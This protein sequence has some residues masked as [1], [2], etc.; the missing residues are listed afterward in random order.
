MTENKKCIW[1]I[2]KYASPL[3]YGFGSRHF[4][5]A[6]EFNRLGHRAVVISS[7]SNHL[8]NIPNFKNLYTKEVIDNVETLWIK[9]F[10]Y[11]G[12]NSFRR[13]LS[14]ID[15]ELKLLLMPVK[16]LSNPDVIICSSLSLFTIL[17]GYIFRK[18]FKCKLI[19]EI[20]DIW[21]LTIIEEGGF[22]KRNPFVI[23]LAWIEQFGY[24][25]ADLIVG[26]MPN[27]AEHVKNVCEKEL[28]CFCIPFGYDPDLYQEQDPLPDGYEDTYIPKNKFIIGYAGSIGVTNA[29]EPLLQCAIEMR[30]KSHIHFLIL[31][32]GDLLSEYKV[33]TSDLKNITFVPKVKKTQVQMFLRY[34]DVLYFSVH[35][36]KVWR[37]GLSLNK[38]IDY[39]LSA[40]PIIASYSG[41]PSMVNEAQCGIFVP[42]KDVSS[43]ITAINDYSTM[44]KAQLSE[45]GQRGREW[46]IKNRPY[47][48]IALEYC[49]FF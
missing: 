12:A 19:F 10:R 28:N 40:K 44:S 41:Y 16:Q 23:F 38:L 42:A 33:R 47:N 48:K 45:I 24:R 2:S 21:P 20:R 4:C 36:S 11:K 30:D 27:L 18:R 1:Y 7:N 37:Y 49:K 46:L 13:I 8:A 22:N 25:T 29:L 9:T 15:F 26:T 43:L 3:S 14:W 34:C 6:R 17:N 31:G 39:M 35:D 32:D 5:L